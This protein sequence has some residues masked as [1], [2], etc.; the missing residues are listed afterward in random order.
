MLCSYKFLLSVFLLCFSIIF[1]ACSDDLDSKEQVEQYTQ[2]IYL[3]QDLISH[4]VLK[5]QM[6]DSNNLTQI[7]LQSQHN[8]KSSI[9]EQNKITLFA[10]FP[11]NCNICSMILPHLNNLGS[12]FENLQ[13]FILHQQ[14]NKQINMKDSLI[15]QNLHFQNLIFTT[16]KNA[17]NKDFTFFLDSLK[18]RLNVEIKNFNAPLFLMLDKNNFITQSYEGSIIEEMLENDIYMLLDDKENH[19]SS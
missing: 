4:Q 12:R 2:E 8:E 15:S 13:I 9:L 19:K 18:R 6:Q 1:H 10:I 16:Q 5:L 11:Q 7:I 3:F 14:E 17:S